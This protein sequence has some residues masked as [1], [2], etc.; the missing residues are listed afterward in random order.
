MQRVL[1]SR[2]IFVKS[3]YLSFLIVQKLP[4]VLLFHPNLCNRQARVTG[5]CSDRDVSV[6]FVRD[7]LCFVAEWCEFEIGE[8]VVADCHSLHVGDGSNLITWSSAVGQNGNIPLGENALVC[9]S[10]IHI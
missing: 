4:V 3:L 6:R 8:C 2:S 9:L 10:L 5:I 1:Q 7:E